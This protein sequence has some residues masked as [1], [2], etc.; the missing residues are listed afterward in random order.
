MTLPSRLDP[1]AGDPLADLIVRTDAILPALIELGMGYDAAP[2]YPHDSVAMLHDAGL[3]FAFAPPESGGIA[4]LDEAGRHRAMFE[5]LRRIGRADLSIGRLY[6][7]HVNALL[8]YDWFGDAAQRAWL[9]SQLAAGSIFGVWA[10]E[11]SPGVRLIGDPQPSVLSGAKH[12]ASGAGGN[13]YAIVTAECVGMHR[14]LVTVRADDQARTDNS[15]WRVRGMRATMSGSYTL[16]GIEPDAVAMLGQP[17]DYDLEPRFT[18][19]AW[20]FCAVQLGGVEALVQAI[21][22]DLSAAA[23]DSPVARARFADAVVAARTACLWVGQAMERASRD[24][25][26][27]IPFVLM[28]RGVVERAALDLIEIASRLL[29]TRS[30]M[31]GNRADKIIRDLSLY[32]R[33]A[34][35][36]HARDRAATAWL[37]HDAWGEDAWW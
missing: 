29:G 7:G 5:V 12:F 1:P 2:A 6:E 22:S 16:D 8:L 26:D 27:A 14:R 28:T 24:D 11:P 17:G 9:G 21:R 23:I 31:E 35:P 18:A 37:D 13:A 15:R 19:G 10:S 25:D 20:R 34:G 4:W 33:Q 36:D 3:L 32:L 30:A